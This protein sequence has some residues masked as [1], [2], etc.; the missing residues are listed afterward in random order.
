L[1]TWEVERITRTQASIMRI[2]LFKGHIA[3]STADC[4]KHEQAR[5][6]LAGCPVRRGTLK[7]YI[8]N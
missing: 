1:L 7:I 6:N 8:F 3:N 5:R 4:G 2:K